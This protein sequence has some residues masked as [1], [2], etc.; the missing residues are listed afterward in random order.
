[1]MVETVTYDQSSKQLGLAG[2]VANADLFHLSLLILGIGVLWRITDIFVLGLGGTVINIFPSK[3]FPLLILLVLFWRYRPSEIPTVLGLSQRNFRGHILLGTVIALTFYLSGV[4]LPA[5]LYRILVN[6]DY[7]LTLRVV[8]LDTLWYQ[9][10]FF[11]TNA[12]MEE[13]LFRGILFH[14]INT[15]TTTGRAMIYSSAVFGVWH[16]CWP[17]ANGLTGVAL[18]TEVLI[19]VVLSAILG[20]FFCIYYVRFSKSATLIGTITTHTL[21]NFL[22]ECFKVGAAS[23]IQGPDTPPS[24][25]DLMVITI[26]LSMVVLMPLALTLYRYTIDDLLTVFHHSKRRSGTKPAYTNEDHLSQRSRRTS[27]QQE[28]PSSG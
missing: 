2:R 15:R 6:H 20:L 4:I 17:F 23:G 5:V 16:I 27:S 12:V 24:A 3:V 18:I 21:I 14:G 19:S 26:V 25:P 8:F 11:F 7:E 1:M 22:N 10:L 9:F 28:L 13:T